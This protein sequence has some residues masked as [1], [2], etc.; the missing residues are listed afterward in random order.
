MSFTFSTIFSAA[1]LA[2]QFDQQ[3]NNDAQHGRVNQAFLA[4]LNAEYNTVQLAQQAR[5]NI[6]APTGMVRFVNHLATAELAPT[7]KCDYMTPEGVKSRRALPPT[8][9]QALHACAAIL[10]QAGKGVAGLTLSPLPAWADPVA[11]D[12]ARKASAKARKASAKAATSAAPDESTDANASDDSTPMTAPDV[13][14]AINMVV[15]A[16]SAGACTATQLQSLR[17]ALE[18][19]Q[20]VAGE[21]AHAAIVATQ[22]IQAAQDSAANAP[23][24][25]PAP[26]SENATE[27]V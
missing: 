12:K 1:N 26:A 4:A 13:Q 18:S 6:Q 5:Y 25:T 24:A 9:V 8:L 10:M 16:L 21:T 23:E 15:A 3:V 20:T 14:A 17:D 27:P 22:A 7:A 11:L 2:Y 19:A